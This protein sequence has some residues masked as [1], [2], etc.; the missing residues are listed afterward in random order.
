MRT[1]RCRIYQSRSI[2]TQQQTQHLQPQIPKLPLRQDW[3]LRFIQRHPNL[4]VKLGRRVEAQR[5]NGV[6]KQVLKG[7]FDAYKSLTTELKIENYNTYVIFLIT[8]CLILLKSG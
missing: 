4:R 8:M 7:W 3:M 5:M 1:N 2:Q 6:T